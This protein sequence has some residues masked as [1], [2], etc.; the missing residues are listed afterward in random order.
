MKPAMSP[1]RLC[2][3]VVHLCVALY[4]GWIGLELLLGDN[5]VDFF[6]M[7]LFEMPRWIAVPYLLLGLTAAGGAYGLLK[8]ARFGLFVAA[9][10]AGAI[11]ILFL[12]ASIVLLIEAPFMT[13][14]LIQCALHL[15][16]PTAT[17]AYLA[18]SKD[19]RQI[20]RG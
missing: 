1:V 16:V 19:I 12:P 13:G 20:V 14:E 18:F 9:V 6:G 7:P 10:H 4:W 15:T 17:L 2:L 8:P 11:L 3:G 5:V